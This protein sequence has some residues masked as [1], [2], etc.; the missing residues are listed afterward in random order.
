MSPNFD[1]QSSS[2]TRL[3]DLFNLQYPIIQGPFGG[4]LSSIELVK[5]VSNG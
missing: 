4:G 3:T 1:Y 5:I 2:H